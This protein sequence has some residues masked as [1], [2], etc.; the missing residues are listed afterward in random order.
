MMKIRKRAACAALALTIISLPIVRADNSLAPGPLL[1][2]RTQIL[3]YLT[4]AERAGIGVGPYS[5]ALARIETAVKAG[6]TEAEI[7][8]QVTRLTTALAEQVNKIKSLKAAA[9]AREA[10]AA[11]LEHIPTP[12]VEGSSTQG[13]APAFPF[14]GTT[15][16]GLPAGSNYAAQSSRASTA[17]LLAGLSGDYAKYM[18]IRGRNVPESIMESLLFDLTNKHRRENKLPPYRHSAALARLA[19]GHASSMAQNSFFAHKDTQH[20][21]PLARAKAAGLSN[22]TVWENIGMAGAGRGTPI[23]MVL[24]VDEAL[25]NSPGHR[26]AI[27]NARGVSGGMGV[28]YD[29]KN[30][31][32][33]ACQVFSPNDI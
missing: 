19:R 4:R 20:Q 21:D 27:L 8:P 7:K 2:K 33:K 24:Q 30:G 26:A 15:A 16:G 23:G 12:P 28:V 25:M 3:E 31:G 14:A 32:I 5:Q 29:I 6:K 17:G 9:A 10:A 22:I 11:A 13:S 1:D 18:L